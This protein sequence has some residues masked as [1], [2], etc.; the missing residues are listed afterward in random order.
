MW[1]PTIGIVIAESNM[2]AS[3]M[4]ALVQSK[5][6]VASVARQIGVLDYEQRSKCQKYKKN[7]RWER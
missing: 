1:V 5:G 3:K 7:S 4:E 6:E 2:A